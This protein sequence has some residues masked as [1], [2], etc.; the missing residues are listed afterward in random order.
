MAPR[1]KH[2][3][4]NVLHTII[5]EVLPLLS[6]EDLDVVIRECFA[7]RKLLEQRQRHERLAVHYTYLRSLP[8]GTAV[9]LGRSVENSRGTIL[10][11]GEIFTIDRALRPPSTNILVLTRTGDRWRVP[12]ECL[13]GPDEVDAV[14]AP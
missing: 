6:V 12:M 11:A 5:R 9:L 1:R 2:Q 13:V 3:Q 10:H 14:A 7:R 4:G 8:A